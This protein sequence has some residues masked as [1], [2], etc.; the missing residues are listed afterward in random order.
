M[1]DSI[2]LKRGDWWD[3]SGVVAFSFSST[4]S[5]GYGSALSSG[6][7]QRTYTLGSLGGSSLDLQ[8]DNLSKPSENTHEIAVGLSESFLVLVMFGVRI[9]TVEAWHSILV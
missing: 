8:I 5:P 4:D 6:D 2:G 1:S 9:Q 7:E 3:P